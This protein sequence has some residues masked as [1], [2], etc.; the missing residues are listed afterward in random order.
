MHV[1]FS[2]PSYLRRA[3]KAVYD[4]MLAADP[5]AIWLECFRLLTELDNNLCIHCRQQNGCQLYFVMI[6][7]KFRSSLAI[8]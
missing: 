5:K 7:G 8:F 3:G 6:F 4:A 2:D 1:F